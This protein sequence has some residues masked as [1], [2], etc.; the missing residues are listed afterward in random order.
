LVDR[1][2][3]F[4]GIT[5]NLSTSPGN[6]QLLDQLRANQVDTSRWVLVMIVF[7]AV[8]YVARWVISYAQQ[9]TLLVVGN[10]ILFDVRQKLFRH[11][12]RLSLRFYEQNPHGWIM[13]RVLYDVDAVQATLSGSLVDLISNT[14][15]VAGALAILYIY[16]WQLALI[17]TL[18]LPLYGSPGSVLAGVLH[19]FRGYRRR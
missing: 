15:L 5:H 10:R 6:P 7:L 18:A 11:L 8:I 19:T 17:A 14:L 13:A 16:D 12:Q 4:A 9:L 1:L 2:T 3:V